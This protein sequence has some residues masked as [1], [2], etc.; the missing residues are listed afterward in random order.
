VTVGIRGVTSASRLSTILVAT[1]VSLSGVV[2]TG[3]VAGAPSTRVSGCGGV[4]SAGPLHWHHA[5]R[6]A[7]AIGDSTMLLAL[8]ALSREGFSV[9]AHGC[10]QYPEAL[11]LL[12]ALRGTDRLPH[13]VVLALGANGEITDR[14][15]DQA[16]EILGRDRLLVLVTPRELGGGAGADAALVRAEGRRHPRRIRVLDWVAYSA[17]HANWFEADG[18]HLTPSGSAALARL[19]GRVLPLAP[20]PKSVEAPRGCGARSSSPGQLAASLELEPNGGTLAVAPDRMVTLTVSNRDSRALVGVA[21]LREAA[22]TVT[23]PSIAANCMFVAPNGS[24]R[25]TLRLNVAAFADLGLRKHYRV[26]L[27]LVLSATLDTPTLDAT[28]ILTPAAGRAGF[29][30]AGSN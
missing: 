2:S 12:A 1:L 17:G 7:L 25:L 30:P 3:I 23:T 13:V 27:E 4:D 5:Y 21:R 11:S 24:A 10:R 14:E 20:P 18:L 29:R 6:P 15:I 26:R 9:N 28:Y 8:P 22:A 16:L 19:L